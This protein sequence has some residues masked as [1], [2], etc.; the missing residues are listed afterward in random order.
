MDQIFTFNETLLR[1]RRAGRTTHC[2]FIDFR[3]A[4]D[5][6]WHQG[7]WRR[8]WEEGVQ[9]KPWRIPRSLYSDL[10]ASVLVEG[11]PSRA[12][13]LRQGVRQGC[14]LSPILFSCYIND[15]VRRLKDLGYGV[16]IGDRDLTA[17]LYADD[18]VLMAD[19]ADK[20][21]R[22][23]DEVDKFCS[24]WRLSLNTK[25]SKV[26]VVAPTKNG[27]SEETG[28]DEP[29]YV[30]RGKPLEIVTEYKYLGVI[31][32]DK[33]LWDR[34]ISM[35]VDKGKAALTL[36]RCLLAQRQLPMK[37]KRLSLTA[38]VRSKLEYA[39]QVWYC[40][41]KQ[42]K[43]LESVQHAGCVWIL[44]V[45]S[46]ANQIAL[47]TILGLPSLQARRDMLR[48]FYVGIVLS[49][50]TDTWP[51]HCFDTEPST[52]NKVRGISQNHWTTRFNSMLNANDQF[53]DGYDSILEHLNVLGGVL[54]ATV[55]RAVTTY[56]NLLLL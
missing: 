27:S 19:S 20:L 41:E 15:L 7:L 17:L 44:R 47:R 16:P 8:L 52:V 9:G 24:E 4:F 18:I 48:L 23:I 45:N 3:K 39:S 33:L 11:E 43:S 53:Q 32:I 14:P 1:Q 6:V 5:T 34:H 37:I 42:A 29:K 10:E 30:F 35:I 21:Q 40:N 56:R 28:D 55:L 50:S 26:M 2:F 12:A 22:M 13:P 54:Q 36:Q 51:R 49:K 25:K 31:F 38:M 46:K